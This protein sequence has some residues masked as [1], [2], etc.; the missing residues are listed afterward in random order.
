MKK[1]GSHI[2][3][4][5]LVLVSLGAYFLLGYALER[6][7]TG[8]VLATFGLLFVQYILMLRSSWD[9]TI[10][11]Q[12]GIAAA[13]IFRLLFLFSVPELSDDI[14]RFIWD[15]NLFVNGINPFAHTPSALKESASLSIVSD[16][17]YQQLNSPDYYS[18]YPPV[19]QYIF[20]FSAWIFG[21][22]LL[23][24]VVTIRLFV[25]GVEL[26]TIWLLKKLLKYYGLNSSYLLIY[27]LNP[28]IIVE[29][30]GNL[31]FE[32]V[33]IFFLV[34]SLYF[35]VIHQ[36]LWALISF[37][38]AVNVKLIPLLLVPYLLFSLSRKQALWLTGVL[39][40]G[41]ILLHMPFLDPSF[42]QNFGDSLGLYFQTFEF[43]ASLYYVIRWV[44]MQVVGYNIIQFAGP[45]LAA[46]STALIFGISW[47]LR[48]RSLKNIPLVFLITLTAYYLFSTTV[49]PWYISSLLV[50]MPLTGMLYPVAWSVVIP[51]S[52][53]TYATA[54]YTENLWL[55]AVEY[56]LLAVVI[57]LDYY[58]T[59]KKAKPR[60]QWLMQEKE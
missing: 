40:G 24:N 3:F 19:C 44:G 16:H 7:Q 42:F 30:S 58:R 11:L 31:H 41:T 36:K 55:V 53:V 37:V 2:R 59:E 57:G 27:A 49:H 14:F 52:Y 21:G 39:G 33:M 50:F 32:A 45:T 23:G 20:G 35:F 18:V 9:T 34:L 5:G 25:I 17:L 8:W 56:L 47:K 54:D 60:L 1:S 29:L 10:K 51:L 46:V 6:S 38:I 15:G 26:G 4:A 28:L 12:W 13:V 22:E 48:D 43:N